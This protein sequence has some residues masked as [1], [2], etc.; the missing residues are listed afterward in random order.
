M[1]NIYKQKRR[2]LWCMGLVFLLAFTALQAQAQEVVVTGKV[3]DAETQRGLPGAAVRVVGTTNGTVTDTDGN[4]SLSVSANGSVKIEISFVGYASV[5][6]EV[7]NGSTVINVA[8]KP[9]YSA[10]DEVVVTGSTLKSAKRELGNNIST[11]NGEALTKS[12]SAN[13]FGALQGKVPGAQI[14][15]NSGDPS[16]GM[17]IRLRGVK[18]LQGNS[19]PLYVIDGVVVSNSTVN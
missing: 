13:L 15:Q 9:E 1:I 5:T 4:F 17:T 6:T 12:G 11:V 18:S 7:T 10:L 8:L 19:D 2:S 3:T 16:G 14:T